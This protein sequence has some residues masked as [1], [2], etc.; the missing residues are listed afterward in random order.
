MPYFYRLPVSFARGLWAGVSLVGDGWK[1]SDVERLR[2]QLDSM[3]DGFIEALDV[4][5]ASAEANAV[6]EGTQ[7]T[8]EKVEMPAALSISGTMHRTVSVRLAG[9]SDM[10]SSTAESSEAKEKE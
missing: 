7:P 5:T 10:D 2:R 4:Q 8:G 3:L 1:V 6:S 9:T